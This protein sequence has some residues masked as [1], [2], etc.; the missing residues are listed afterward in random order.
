MKFAGG[1]LLLM[2]V[3]VFAEHSEGTIQLI[4]L[5]DLA[6]QSQRKYKESDVASTLR[7]VSW[8]WCTALL[9]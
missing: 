3:D 4:F 8:A 7:Q 6:V 1:Y 2:V 9:G 5:T